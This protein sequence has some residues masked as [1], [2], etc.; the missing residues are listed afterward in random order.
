MKYKLLNIYREDRKC[1]GIEKALPITN[2]EV[3]PTN[4]YAAEKSNGLNIELI[5]IVAVF[6]VTAC[7]K[8]EVGTT[9]AVTADLAGPP[10]VLVNPS[11]STITY[12]CQVLSAS[13]TNS[14]VAIVISM[15]LKD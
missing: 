5:C 9:F 12:I 14:R 6:E 15:K 1:V 2:T 13:V 11:M 4:S 8:C 7:I 3:S 10:K